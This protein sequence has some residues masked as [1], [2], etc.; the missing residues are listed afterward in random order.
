VQKICELSNQFL[1]HSYLLADMRGRHKRKLLLDNVEPKDKLYAFMKE[2]AQKRG[3]PNMC[4]RDATD[5]VNGTGSFKGADLF[6]DYTPDQTR[7]LLSYY[8]MPET[9]FHEDTVR[10]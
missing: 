4:V 5:F 2:N 8:D 6:E 9:C 7:A 1:K 3:K 10:V